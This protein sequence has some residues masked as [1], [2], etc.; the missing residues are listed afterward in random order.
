MKKIALAIAGLLVA[1]SAYAFQPTKGVDGVVHLGI[2]GF[3]AGVESSDNM[4]SY[5]IANKPL[6]YSYGGNL[7]VGGLWGS[8]TG[9]FGGVFFGGVGISGYIYPVANVP[10]FVGITLGAN[11]VHATVSGF[12]VTGIEF[13]GG[14]A[15]GVRFGGKNND[16]FVVEWGTPATGGYTGV[17]LGMRF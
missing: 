9:G 4:T 1:S 10:F 3:G 8:S 2:N 17:G 12:S 16:N 6:Y 13:G 5:K 11:I 15:L 7:G 14:L